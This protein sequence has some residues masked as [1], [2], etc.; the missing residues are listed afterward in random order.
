MQCEM[1][2]A[3][4]PLVR[5]KVEGIILK[6]CNKCGRHGKILEEIRVTVKDEWGNRTEIAEMPEEIIVEEHPELIKNARL[7]R[8]QSQEEFAKLITEKLS[9]LQKMESGSLRPSVK[10]AKKLEKLLGIKLIEKIKGS[11][12]KMASKSNKNETL[13]LGHLLKKDKVH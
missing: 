3:N 8:K 10:T 13:T 4:K 6:V 5:A 12:F 9:A 7:K 11:D 2:G 1:C